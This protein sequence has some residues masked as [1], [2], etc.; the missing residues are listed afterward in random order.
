MKH[1]LLILYFITYLSIASKA[2]LVLPNVF[3]DNMV[4]QQNSTVAFWGWG[5]PNENVK[6][7]PSWDN[8]T[9]LDTVSNYGKWEV[10][11]KTPSYGGPYTI[12]I[13]GYNKIEYSNVMLGEVWLASGQ[14]N[15]QWS[16]AAGIIGGEKEIPLAN[17]PNIRFFSVNKNSAD[18]EQQNLSATW[19]VCTPETMK[20]F[21]AVGYFFAKNVFEK[22]NIPVGVINSS[23]GGTPAE[24]WTP[25]E[26]IQSDEVLLKDAT[27]LKEVPWGPV[28][29]GSIY[30]AM[31]A[32]L[33]KYAIAGTL[34]Y[35]GEANVT[36]AKNYDR[37]LYTLVSSWRAKWGM[38][39]PFYYAQIA[40]Y[41]YGQNDDGV[42]L[43]N[44]QN[45]ALKTITNSSMIVLTDIGNIEDIHP[46]NKIDV[47]KRF[48]NVALKNVYG[49]KDVVAW[50]PSVENVV[51]SKK[52]IVLNYQASG[53]L[54]CN[55]ACKNAFEIADASGKYK[56]A[57][58]KIDGNKITLSNKQIAFPTNARFS[59]SNVSTD[60]LTDG[61]GLPASSMT[62]E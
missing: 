43:R 20:H 50:G 36:H 48:A 59:W 44:A 55:D 61:S 29:A 28:R 26:A 11:L 6:L 58:V 35:Q 30:N 45:E 54:I 38:D 5:D 7:T 31:I 4:L 2:T 12:K 3:S 21:S 15:M 32:P 60:I 1:C 51:K 25:R 53:K 40:P 34:W 33:T 39:F 27:E 57:D 46:R 9:Y 41:K 19:T 16:T 10:K 17:F 18:G 52:E 23:W 42:A 47:G 8:I 13:E 22:T 24:A 56:K 37:L 62:T 14:S 49:K